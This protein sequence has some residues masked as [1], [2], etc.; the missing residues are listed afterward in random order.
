MT[1]YFFIILLVCVLDQLTKFWSMDLIAVANGIAVGELY[2]GATKPILDG[3]LNFT[4]I[5]N[6]G[7]AFGL[8]GEHRWIFMSLST[9]GIAAMICYLIYLKGSDKLFS[10]SLALVIGGGIGNMFDRVA[11]GYVVDFIDVR[12][13][14]FWKWIF[15]VADSAVCIGAGLIILAVILDGVR[16]GKK[17]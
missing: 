7:M 4:F 15:N 10:F 17:K 1:V 11:L 16:E 8:L 12:C 14:S 13:F 3:V 2:E 9:V 6:D 5:K